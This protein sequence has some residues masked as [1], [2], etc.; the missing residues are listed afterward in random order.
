MWSSTVAERVMGYLPQD[1][2]S[3]RM[4]FWKRGWKAKWHQLKRRKW[5]PV[6]ASRDRRD[7]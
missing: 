2:L 7:M 1:N 5:L 4:L 3:L 6:D